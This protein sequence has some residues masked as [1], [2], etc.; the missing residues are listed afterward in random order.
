MGI[1][2]LAVFFVGGMILLSRVDVEAGRQM[3]IE[4][5]A[6]METVG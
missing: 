6:D 5:E 3:A 1:A 4:A 2:T